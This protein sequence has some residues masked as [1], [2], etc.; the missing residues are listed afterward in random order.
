MMLMYFI[1][2]K[3]LEE[4][5]YN[6]SVRDTFTAYFVEEF[7]EDNVRVM[8]YKKKPDEDWYKL[9]LY[10]DFN[11]YEGDK[12]KI[13][14]GTYDVRELVGMGKFYAGVFHDR[15]ITQGSF[16]SFE[17]FDKYEDLV[18]YGEKNKIRIF[19]NYVFNGCREKI[20]LD[21]QTGKS[22]E[23]VLKN[24]CPKIYMVKEAKLPNAGHTYHGS[25][26]PVVFDGD[27][28]EMLIGARN[29]YADSSFEEWYRE[30]FF[31]GEVGLING[32]TIKIPRLYYF[33]TD[34]NS[35]T[36]TWYVTASKIGK[37]AK[38]TTKVSKQGE[39]HYDIMGGNYCRKFT[40]NGEYDISSFEFFNI[41]SRNILRTDSPCFFEG[42]SCLADYMIRNPKFFE[43]SGYI[44]FISSMHRSMDCLASVVLFISLIYEYPSVELLIKAGHFTLVEGLFSQI[45]SSPK[46]ESI[47]ENVNA[48]GELISRDATNGSTMFRFP[49]YIGNYLKASN[50]TISTY[51]FW[52]DIYEI[53]HISKENFE[54][55]MN[56]P[57]TALISLDMHDY[58][59]SSDLYTTTWDNIGLQDIIKYDGWKLDKTVRYAVKN[60]IANSPD[61]AGRA[62]QSFITMFWIIKDTLM[63]AEELGVDVEPYPR[64]IIKIHQELSNMRNEVID[65]E[66]DEF[67]K[68][69]SKTCTNAVDKVFSSNSVTLPVKAMEKLT[70]VFPESQQEF[71]QEGINQHNCVSGYCRSVKAGGCIV[72]FVRQKDNPQSSYITAE[73]KLESGLRQVMYSNNRPV[74][75][76]SSD[77]SY[78]M[79]IA[80]AVLN[81]YEKGEVC[82]FRKMLNFK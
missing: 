78:C 67:L 7:L 76:N 2:R 32:T 75:R 60:V 13:Q 45:I 23:Y 33:E 9:Y 66:G 36:I 47:I 48:I 73:I 31:Y 74:P 53:E 6:G 22:D 37:D 61:T 17:V 40:K 1:G 30:H 19:K 25:S 64:D 69:V 63:I 3:K 38:V 35:I 20:K 62:Y 41:N 58:N 59:K 21:N 81:A 68:K 16:E 79:H 54:K 70:Y 55:F 50:A 80:N 44:S 29:W 14:S 4:L 12:E 43:K 8:L 26:N 71:T 46:K 27:G 57:Q 82:G 52:R 56:M 10:E 65:K 11:L 15:R 77:Y 34:D 39:M 24:L 51:K 5:N 72:F 42:A 49:S 18:E 28:K